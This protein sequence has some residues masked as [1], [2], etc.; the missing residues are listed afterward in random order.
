MFDITDYYFGFL[1]DFD[2]KGPFRY[3]YSRENHID[4]IKGNLIIKFFWD[5]GPS[6]ELIKTKKK[7]PEL[8]TGALKIIDIDFKDYIYYDI[9]SLD[10]KKR[11]FNSVTFNDL[12]EKI[13]WYNSNLLKSNTEILQGDLRK[14][15]IL[16]RFLRWVGLNR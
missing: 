2:F 11:Y 10:Y 12:G 5:G 4:Y 6:V 15:N 3:D 7:I 14:F 8:E 1:K 16:N 9:T 13:L